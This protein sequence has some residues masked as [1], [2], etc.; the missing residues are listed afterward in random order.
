[1]PAAHFSAWLAALSGA[2][3]ALGG[4]IGPTWIGMQMTTGTPAGGSATRALE[5]IGFFTGLGV[6]IVLVAAMA[7]GRFSVIGV[8]DA[9]LAKSAT[10]A[11]PATPAATDAPARTGAW[12]RPATPAT[13]AE[14]GASGTAAKP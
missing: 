1:R 3:F 13:P 14:P 8:R 5:Q 7:L 10:S 12:P 11:E 4:V 6:A 2:W 9:R